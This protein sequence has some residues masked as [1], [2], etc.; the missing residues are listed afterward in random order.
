MRKTQDLGQQTYAVS[1]DNYAQA[2]FEKISGGGTLTPNGNAY[3]L[4]L[5]TFTQGSGPVTVDLGVSNSAVGP[6]DMLGGTFA[7]VGD[8]AF[9]NGGFAQ[10]S[11]VG[12]GQADT[13]PTVTL[14]T[15][16]SGTFSETITLDPNG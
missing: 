6:A 2:A 10:F 12:A 5:G 1:L 3:S 13:A 4:D 7:I 16:A 9:T 8:S 15:G 11:G 14:D